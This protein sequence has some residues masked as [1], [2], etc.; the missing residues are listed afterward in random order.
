MK[1]HIKIFIF[2]LLFFSVLNISYANPVINDGSSKIEIPYWGEDYWIEKWVTEVW[3]NVEWLVTDQTAS[4]YFQS[5]IIYLL[6]FIY[7]IAVSIIIYSWFNILTWLWDEEKV[8]KS[9]TIISYTIINK[10][11]F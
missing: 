6:G 8:K 7:L 1:I 4:D 10:S 3:E 2:V 11:W 9:K 5:I